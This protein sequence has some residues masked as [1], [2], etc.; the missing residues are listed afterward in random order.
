MIEHVESSYPSLS[1]IGCLDSLELLPL[2]LVF[3][4]SLLRYI[5][6]FN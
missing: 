6:L 3:S 1:Q 5:L 4:F 2:L